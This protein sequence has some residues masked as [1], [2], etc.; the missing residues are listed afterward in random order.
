MNCTSLSNLVCTEHMDP[1]ELDT[2]TARVFWRRV[3][4]A[5]YGMAMPFVYGGSVCGAAMDVLSRALD[6][7]NGIS[8]CYT[9]S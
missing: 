3:E 5:M 6:D 8:S 4:P 2:F 7:L 9:C 1:E